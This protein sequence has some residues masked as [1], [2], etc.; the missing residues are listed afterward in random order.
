MRKLVGKLL[1]DTD[2]EGIEYIGVADV[3]GNRVV[4]LKTVRGNWLLHVK[5]DIEDLIPI[6]EQAAAEWAVDHLST[7]TILEFFDVELA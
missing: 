2:A 1:Y 6:S 4:L 7:E 5:S 3:N